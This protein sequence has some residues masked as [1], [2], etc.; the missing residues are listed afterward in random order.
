MEGTLFQIGEVPGDVDTRPP[1]ARRRID[2][3]FRLLLEEAAVVERAE[4]VRRRELE[5]ASFAGFE[6][7]AEPVELAAPESWS[8][9]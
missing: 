7:D 4:P 2:T 6:L 9:D 5:R 1:G 8:S 3:Q